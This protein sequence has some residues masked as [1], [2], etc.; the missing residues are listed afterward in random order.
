MKHSIYAIAGATLLV[1]VEAANPAHADICDQFGSAVVARKY[2]VQ[3]NRWNNNV[4]G[5]QCINVLDQVGNTAPGFSIT[6]Q[7]GSAR[8]DGPQCRTHPST[9]AA[10]TTAARPTQTYRYRSSRSK[11]RRPAS[12]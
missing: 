10:T 3:N 12:T 11:G 9:S 6:K 5:D 1:A 8:T 7:T 2:V 4:P